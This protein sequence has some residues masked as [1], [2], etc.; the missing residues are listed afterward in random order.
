VSLKLKELDTLK[1]ARNRALADEQRALNQERAIELAI[2]SL[3]LAT[4]ITALF[5]D[6]IKSRGIYGLITGAVASAAFLILW[7]QYKSQA[8]AST[9]MA[10]G[11]SGTDTGVVKGRSHAA[12]GER[13][14]D[15][16]EVE[17][18]EAWGVLSVPATQKYGKIFHQ[19]VSSFN[20]GDM[21]VIVPPASVTNR[22]LVNNDGSNS[23]LDRLIEENH[24]LNE[25]L[26]RQS[27]YVQN[28]G[29]KTIY[30]KGDNI[31]I[32]R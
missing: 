7:S 2:Q 3:N 12:G 21:P 16:I 23:R 5:K 24:E 4:S 15:Q 27:E 9:K 10:Q 8:E 22:V 17:R 20:H 29:G 6:E 13:F 26:S 11:G 1:S 18:G 14:V 30:K 19:M 31:R 28:L 25:K 32:V